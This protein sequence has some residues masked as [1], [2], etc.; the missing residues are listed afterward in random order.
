VTRLAP[1]HANARPEH[2]SKGFA[3]LYTYRKLITKTDTGEKLDEKERCSDAKL[4]TARVF[5][6]RH[7]RK[8][9]MKASPVEGSREHLGRPLSAGADLNQS[10]EAIH[11]LSHHHLR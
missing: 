8:K 2:R 6:N 3:A 11:L 9:G 7:R 5:V 1:T 4:L 10:H